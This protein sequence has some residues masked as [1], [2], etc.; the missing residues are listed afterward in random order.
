MRPGLTHSL[1]ALLIMSAFLACKKETH[2]PTPPVSPVP[3]PTVYVLGTEADSVVYWK[4]GK[5]NPVYSATGI[6]Y[7]FGAASL[8]ASGSNVYIA[9]F[10]PVN[11][12]LLYPYA[13]VFW[14]NGAA[15]P[16]PDSNGS[17]TNGSANS[18]AVSGGDVYVAG[19]RGYDSQKDLVPYTNDSATYPITGSV[20]TVWKN[21]S[22][23]AL[24]GYNSV[25][26]VDSGKYANRFYND[27]VNAIYV[28]GSDVY[29]SGGTSYQSAAHARYWKNGVPVDLA[30]SLNYGGP[31]NTFGFPQ[32]T[33][34]FV[35]GSDVYVSGLQQ[36][37]VG[38]PVA[39][40]WNN[41]S[42][43]FLSTDSA[44]GSLASSVFVAGSDVYVAGWQNVDNYSRAMLWKNGTAAALTGHDTSSAATAVIVSGKDVYVAGYTWVAP[45]NYMASYWKNGSLVLLTN[46][47]TSAI[48]YS[49]IVE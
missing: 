27:Y 33:G 20:A 38:G 19:I 42:P 15:M 29:V 14:L 44:S 21:G 10:E 1:S 5:L 6:L 47:S 16:L 45:N 30:G 43:V 46:P 40:Y 11:T 18:I 3:P 9:G 41:G 28:S 37:T 25:G 8:A 17:A 23:V 35:S 32:T 31:G 12:S 34:I 26:L 2:S 22:P 36:T 49:I 4:D 24:P 48:A 13:P 39:I 7:N